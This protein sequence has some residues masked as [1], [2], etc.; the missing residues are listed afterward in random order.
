MELAEHLPKLS[1]RL[2][3]TFGR[4]KD[5]HSLVRSYVYHPRF[6]GSFSLKSV[7]PALVPEMRYE[8]L[9]IQEGSHASLEYLRM[10]DSSTPPVE[11]KRIQKA[12][13]RY[14]GQDTLAMMKIRDELLSRLS[15][16]KAI[17]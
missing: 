4:F 12:L 8:D 17:P 11:K 2:C 16:R 14:C 3:A 5:L 6:Y 7:L 13:R 9:A 10:V 15:A 1:D